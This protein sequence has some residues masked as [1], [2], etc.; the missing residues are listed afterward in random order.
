MNLS[1]MMEKMKAHP[2]YDRVGMVLYHNG[3]VRGTSRDGRLVNGLRVKVDEAGLEKAIAANKKTPGIIDIQ[4]WI[5]ADKDLTVGE[6]VMLLGV[7]GDIREN[8]IATLTKTLN[9][10]KTSVTSKTE[11]F[12]EPD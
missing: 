8:V 3:V 11:F 9:T 6:D 10:I 5:N 7:A 2:D 1:T 12:V 4:I